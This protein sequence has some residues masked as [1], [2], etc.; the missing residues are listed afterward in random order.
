MKLLYISNVSSPRVLNYIFETSLVKPGQAAQ[1]FHRLLVEGFSVNSNICHIE[2][3]SSLPV[4][5]RSHKKVFW[6]ISGDIWQSVKFE[7][8]PFI[9]FPVIKYLFVFF[10]TFFK[11][12]F[13][14]IYK[15]KESVV[16]CDILNTSIVWAAFLACK[17]ANHPI[18]VIVTDLPVFMVSENGKQSFLKKMYLKISSF[19]LSNFDYYIGLTMQMNEVVNPFKKP[20]LVMEG[21]VDCSVAKE[22]NRSVI[23][24]EKRILLYAGGIYT[25]YGVKDLLEAF[26]LLSG[27]NLEMHIYGSGDLEVEMPDY[28]LKDSRIKYFGTVSNNIVV[29]RL[30]E[31]TLLINPRPITEEFTKFSFPSKNME[32]MVSGTPLL[33]TKLPGMP[34]EYND[35]VYLFETEKALGM[36]KTLESLLLKSDEELILFGKKAQQFVLNNKSNNL[37]AKKIIDF[38]KR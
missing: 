8:V 24:N 28:I 26:M 37:Q 19:V 22:L 36:N 17:L 5:P 25:K 29:E 10:I 1:K 7:Y 30:K 13:W 38:F 12:F 34:N 31:A 4:A 18:A 9:N 2:V 33:T 14:C 3:L 20:F 6:N 27:D 11:V 16:V 35:Y 23:K 21:L 15:T 32:Y